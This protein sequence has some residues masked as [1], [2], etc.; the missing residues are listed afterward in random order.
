MARCTVA[1]KLGS[2]SARTNYATLRGSSLPLSGRSYDERILR[3]KQLQAKGRRSEGQ[4]HES[5]R[6][7]RPAMRSTRSRRQPQL[8][9]ADGH[10]QLSTW[11]GQIVLSLIL[12]YNS[13][14]E[15]LDVFYSR[16]CF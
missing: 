10:P 4:A 13:L 16:D 3:T 11:N 6:K 12:A 15:P 2:V 7:R 1:R 14:R 9:A 5:E 8:L